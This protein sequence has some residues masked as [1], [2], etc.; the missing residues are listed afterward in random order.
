MGESIA[1]IKQFVSVAEQFANMKADIK[2][3]LKHTSIPP[4]SLYGVMFM[5][6]IKQ[7]WSIHDR[8]GMIVLEKVYYC[9]KGNHF[10]YII[11]CWTRLQRSQKEYW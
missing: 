11:Q 8:K 7:Y 4:T 6:N 3:L 9:N 1:E 2:N 5:N 10:F